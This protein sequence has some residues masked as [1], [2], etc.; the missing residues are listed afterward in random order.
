MRTAFIL[1]IFLTFN[2]L[3]YS[4]H[5]LGKITDSKTSKSLPFVNIVIKGTYNGTTTNTNGEFS[6]NLPTNPKYRTLVF[7]CIGYETKE[8]SIKTGETNISVQL[9]PHAYDISEVTIMPDSTLR[10]F[11]RKAFN[12]IPDNYPSYPSKYEGFCRTSIQ[13]EKGEY[14]RFME[15]LTEIYKSSY[16]NKEEGTIKVIDSRKYIN[17]KSFNE[18][19]LVFYGSSHYVHTNDAVKNRAKYLEGGHQFNYQLTGTT[20]LNNNTIY[21][22]KFRP[23]KSNRSFCSGNIYIDA[24]SLAYVKIEIEYSDKQ[25]KSRFNLMPENLTSLDKSVTTTYIK[26]DSIYRINALFENEHIKTA[27][28]KVISSPLEYIITS[29]SA[30]NVLKIPFDSISPITFTPAFQAN[31]YSESNWKDY[32]ILPLNN[33][34]LID[35]ITS[36]NILLSQSKKTQYLNWREILYKI[37]KRFEYEYGVEIIKTQ[38]PKALYSFNYLNLSF[39]NSFQSNYILSEH[40]SI[41]YK[42]NS[43][44]QLIYISNNPFYKNNFVDKTSFKYNRVIPLKTLGKQ[45]IGNLNLGWQWQKVGYSLGTEKSD[46]DFSFGGKKFKNDKIQAYSG[47]KMNGLTIGASI[48]YQI[49]NRLYLNLSSN[50]LSPIKTEDIITLQERSGFFLFRKHA[51]EPISNKNIDYFIN[52]NPSNKSGIKFNNWSFGIGIKMKI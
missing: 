27:N 38:I 51:S 6:I 43:K 10:S 8:Y 37:L 3:S 21:I 29:Y 50:Y 9:T 46:H 41:N 4:E 44:N 25:L 14:L 40:S 35:S 48:D 13:N 52:G 33:D 34:F 49:S 45:I 7:S 47:L 31:F 5:F 23:T 16:E 1:V 30:N 15:V 20:K 42:I 28:N 22:I 2:K 36:K 32:N 24:N 17:N 39:Q 26:E 11:L 12:K 19:P 18:F